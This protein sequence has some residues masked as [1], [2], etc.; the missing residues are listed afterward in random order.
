MRE[1]TGNALPLEASP[2][3][4]GSWMGGDRDGNPN[5][6]PGV[7]FEV[8]LLSRWIAADLYSREIDALIRELSLTDCNSELR[9]RVGSVPE[10][11]RALLRQVESR[12]MDT[13]K[14]I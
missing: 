8:C 1:F 4:F 2:V 7:T 13:K 14:A 9:A 3:R 11:Y 5:V 12:L 10:P 6:T